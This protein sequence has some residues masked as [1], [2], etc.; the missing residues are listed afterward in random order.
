MPP[1]VVTVWPENTAD[2]FPGS[3]TEGTTV[4]VNAVWA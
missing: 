1:S 2:G 3:G 4:T